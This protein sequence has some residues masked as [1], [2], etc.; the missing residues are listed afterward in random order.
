[1]R[2][3]ASGI[4]LADVSQRS[5]L[6]Y[7]LPP[8]MHEYVQ[9]AKRLHGSKQRHHGM[10]KQKTP[11]D[12]KQMAACKRCQQP[13]STAQA[14]KPG[15]KAATQHVKPLGTPHRHAMWR[16]I[17]GML[18]NAYSLKCLDRLPLPPCNSIQGI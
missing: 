18:G 6:Y 4:R 14:K 2:K 7:N 11:V 17:T 8:N 12:T 1:M 9:I 5:P 15:F 16:G 13:Q 10:R 3:G